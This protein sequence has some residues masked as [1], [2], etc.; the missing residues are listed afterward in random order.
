MSSK[1]D[2]VESMQDMIEAKREVPLTGCEV[3]TDGRSEL[4]LAGASLGWA[5]CFVGARYLIKRDL[6]PDGALTW[7]VAVLPAVAGAALLLMYSRYLRAIDE[8]Q[9][10]IQ[11]QAMALGFGGGFLAICAY[12][13]LQPLGAPAADSL[14]LLA[15]MPILYAVAMLAGSG[16]YR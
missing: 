3:S 7:L 10:A 1:H 14:T 8:M 16:R 12:S 4:R 6:V 13:T 5:I 15:I 2:Y 9:R 11:L